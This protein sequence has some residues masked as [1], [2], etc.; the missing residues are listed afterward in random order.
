MFCHI[1]LKE[2]FLKNIV[3]DVVIYALFIS[4]IIF[5]VKKRE[6]YSESAV[7][8][9]LNNLR[10]IFAVEVLIG[11]VVQYQSGTLLYPLSLFMMCS[12]GFFFFISA[13]SMTYKLNNSKG[14]LD[15]FF[16]VRK[17]V[18]LVVVTLLVYLFGCLISLWT[19]SGVWYFDS[20]KQLLLGYFDRTNWY[21]WILLLFYMLFFIFGRFEK[22]IRNFALLI[23]VLAFCILGAFLGWQERYFISSLC[24]PCG[25][26]FGDYSHYFDKKTNKLIIFVIVLVGI[27]LGGLTFIFNMGAIGNLL[28]KNCFCISFVI[29]LILVTKKFVIN[30]L[31][32]RFFNSISL[33]IFLFSF[34][35]ISVFQNLGITYE[36]VLIGSLFMSVTSGILIRPVFARI[37]SM[38][39]NISF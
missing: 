10:G 37:K 29:I 5:G 22:R 26:I 13:Y 27:V 16:L 28:C 6:N 20:I 3:F 9:N 21:I 23:L 33:E 36:Y 17:V 15:N 39:N 24:F 38:I 11:H 19:K 30:N 31:C 7:L 14:Y 18:Y 1:F 8:G 32:I 2:S 35:W 25:M 34:L 12:V 4:I